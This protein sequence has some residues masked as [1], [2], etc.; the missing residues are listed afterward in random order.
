MARRW[1]T[2]F[3]AGLFFTAVCCSSSTTGPSATTLHGEVTDPTGDAT[4]DARVF[5]PPDLVRAT[6][7]VAAGN[8]TFVI[9][10]APGTLDLK[11]TRVSVQ[12]DTDQDGSTGIRQPN[13]LGADYGFDMNASTALATIIKA[14][15]AGC[16]AHFSCFNAVASAPVTVSANGLQTTVSLSVLGN[17]DGRMSFQVNTNILVAPLTSVVF[18]FMPNTNLPPGRVQ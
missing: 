18:D 8:V 16:A 4:P 7:D 6:V 14:D 9:Q 3:A 10:L 13:G 17:D 11:T 5:L 1:P 15:P 2:A 12:L